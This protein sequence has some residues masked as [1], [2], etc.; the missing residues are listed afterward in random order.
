VTKRTF[1]KTW[2]VTPAFCRAGLLADLMGH[3][4]GNTDP[5][6]ARAAA[7]IHQHVIIDN[8]YPLPTQPLNSQGLIDIADKYDLVYIDSGRDRGLHEG[9]NHALSWLR[10]DWQ[11]DLLIGNDPDDRCC[12]DA[13]RAMREVME[14]DDRVAVC[15]VNFS[16]IR[17]RLSEGKLYQSRIADHRVLIHPSLEMWNVAAFDLSLVKQAGG[18]SEPYKYYGGIEMSLYRHWSTR[19]MYLVYLEDFTSEMVPVPPKLMDPE[20][21]QWKTAHLAGFEG[22]FAQWL[23][24]QRGDATAGCEHSDYEKNGYCMECGE[25]LV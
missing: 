23:A 24:E 20:Y 10:I 13:F 9:L 4:Y 7:G 2:L 6:A 17:E 25:K 16:V 5:A 11:H 22:G 15:G 18:F 19:G 14:A 12:F 8:H 3:L 1:H 21:R